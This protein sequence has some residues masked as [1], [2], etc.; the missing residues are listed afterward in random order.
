[1]RHDVARSRF[2]N[3]TS[4]DSLHY[5]VELVRRSQLAGVV[6][7]DDAN[8]SSQSKCRAEG[9]YGRSWPPRV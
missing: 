3:Y 6:D 9:G 8:R 7:G 1:M 5:F 2:G 4:F